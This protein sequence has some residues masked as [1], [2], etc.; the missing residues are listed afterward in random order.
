MALYKS[1]HVSDNK[2]TDVY[3]IKYGTFIFILLSVLDKDDEKRVCVCVP[4]LV[5]GVYLDAVM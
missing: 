4:A 5:E 3:S 2:K 1:Q